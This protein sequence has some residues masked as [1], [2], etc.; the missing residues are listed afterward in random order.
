MSYVIG[1][2]EVGL[3]ALAGDL[4][5]GA[6]VLP[7]GKSV[8]GVKDSKRLSENKRI[9]LIKAIDD[10]SLFW[11]MAKSSPS[12]IDTYGVKNCNDTCAKYLALICLAKFPEANVIVDGL[13][14]IKG[15]PKHK[16]QAVPKADSKIPAV[17]AA[18]VL[19]KVYRDRGMVMEAS[20]KWPEYS[21]WMHKGYGTS[22]HLEMLKKYGPC[23]IHR[24][25]YRIKVLNTEGGRIKC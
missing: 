25:S 6:V 23:P 21:F 4:V 11:I 5:V 14:P 1:I 3:G 18:S 24:K 10:E 15:V 19:A 22:Y 16:Q 8:S 7:V 20:E 13:T 9:S 12:A 17:S 2:D